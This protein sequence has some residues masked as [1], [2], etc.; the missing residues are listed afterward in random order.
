L[1][2]FGGE[3]P[4]RVKELLEVKTTGI[5]IERLRKILRNERFVVEQE[6]L[7]LISPNYEVKFGLKP[8]KQLALIAYSPHLRNFVTTCSYCLAREAAR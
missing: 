4:E 2:R 7:F 8:R 6:V 3:K 1:L 5:T